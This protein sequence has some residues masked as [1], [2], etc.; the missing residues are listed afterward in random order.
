MANRPKKVKLTKAE[1]IERDIRLAYN[2]QERAVEMR[3]KADRMLR[4]SANSLASLHKA[5]RRLEAKAA[6]ALVETV[7]EVKLMPPPSQPVC[8]VPIDGGTKP[9]PKP[10]RVRKPKPTVTET[11]DIPNAE[12][13]GDPSVYDKPK[14]G[15][16]GPAMLEEYLNKPFREAREAKMKAM[17]FRKTKRKGAAAGT[18]A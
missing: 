14:A 10:K 7:A 8:A 3:E 12:I 11:T 17:G 5:K 16:P 4:T 15:S 13:F 9:E 1:K 18:T 6:D 2:K